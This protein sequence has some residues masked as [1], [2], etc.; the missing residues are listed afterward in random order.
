MNFQEAKEIA[1]RWTESLSLPENLKGVQVNT[2][3]YLHDEKD[4]VLLQAK[5]RSLSMLLKKR[6]A[7]LIHEADSWSNQQ[8]RQVVFTYMSALK[9]QLTGDEISQTYL[10]EPLCHEMFKAEKPVRFKLRHISSILVNSE[11]P[12]LRPFK[13]LARANIDIVDWNETEVLRRE[14]AQFLDQNPSLYKLFDETACSPPPK[15]KPI[16]AIV[17]E[18]PPEKDI[19]DEPS[20]RERRLRVATKINYAEREAKNRNLGYSGEEL[21]LAYEKGR[22]QRAGRSDLAER[23]SW[24]SRDFGDGLGFDIGSFE[25]NGTPRFIEVKTTTQGK[26]AAFYLSANEL[27]FSRENARSFYIYRVFD[28]AREPRLFLLHGAVENHAKIVPTSYRVVF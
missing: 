23:I 25:V 26:Y 20:R 22:L 15:A 8:A 12:Y 18:D 9:R 7:R 4:P 13:P 27:E 21:V 2:L 16:E 14:I 1:R 24:M 10:K 3:S 17:V 6:G 28:F 11:M 19:F 5:K